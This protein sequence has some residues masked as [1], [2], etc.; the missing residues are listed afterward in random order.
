[1]ET[2]HV[3]ETAGQRE[4]GVSSPRVERERLYSHANIAKALEE[5]VNV[6]FVCSD[7]WR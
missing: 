7:R 4:H 3:S 5:S 1:M 2:E 6:C